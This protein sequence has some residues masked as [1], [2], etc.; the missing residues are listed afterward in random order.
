MPDPS[1]ATL[2]ALKQVRQAMRALERDGW[3]THA[4]APFPRHRRV[5]L[6]EAGSLGV[7]VGT[8]DDHGRAWIEDAG[9]LWPSRPIA[10][11]ELVTSV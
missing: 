11:K 5:M 8:I 2:G 7:H 3:K 6:L 9:D 10:W 4:Q 1:E